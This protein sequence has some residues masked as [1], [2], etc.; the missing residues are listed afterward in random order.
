MNT[1]PIPY[2]PYILY[3]PIIAHFCAIC[4]TEICNKRFSV[5]FMTWVLKLVTLPTSCPW[6]GGACSSWCFQESTISAFIFLK[7]SG[8]KAWDSE[9]NP[10]HSKLRSDWEMKEGVFR[11]QRRLFRCRA[12]SLVTVQLRT[13]LWDV[14][15]EYDLFSFFLL[16]RFCE[17]GP[18]SS[19]AL[20][21][22]LY[23]LVPA[24]Q[25]YPDLLHLGY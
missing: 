25:L 1:K 12:S 24:D 14:N 16:R 6:L 5:W 3:Y 20:L 23:L 13:I 10:W 4:I 21:Q 19:A 18:R 2:Y 17:S 11:S 22:S 15:R 8:T 9:H 7:A